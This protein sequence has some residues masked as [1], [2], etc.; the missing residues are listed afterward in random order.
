MKSWDLIDEKEDFFL[1]ANLSPLFTGLPFVVW[2]SAKGYARHDIR[3]KVSPGMKVKQGELISVALRPEVREIGE[4]RLKAE[5]LTQLRQWVHLNWE[6][7]LA[8]WNG[9]IATEQVI[10]RLKPIGQP[11]TE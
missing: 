5:E 11:A 4:G 1:M 9:E 6:A 8:F 7:L 3:L 10:P 2:I